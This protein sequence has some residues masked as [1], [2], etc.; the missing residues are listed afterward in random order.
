MVSL[1]L[2]WRHS[3][4][5][6]VVAWGQWPPWQ[7]DLLATGLKEEL[8]VLRHARETEEGEGDPLARVESR[9]PDF[10]DVDEVLEGLSG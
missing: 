4:V 9:T 3:G 5:E 6:P 2:L 8:E 7:F 1:Y 10:G